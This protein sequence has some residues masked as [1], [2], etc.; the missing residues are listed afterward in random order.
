MEAIVKISWSK[1]SSGMWAAKL[2]TTSFND[3]DHKKLNIGKTLEF[4]VSDERRCIGY[5]SDIGER[6]PCPRFEKLNSGYQCSSCRRKDVYTGYIEGRKK[7]RVDS[8]FSVY[9][10]RCG[11][12]I[13]VGV[14]RS[15]KIKKRWIEQG[16]DKAVEIYSGL[17]SEQAL[18]KEK[19]L[20]ENG[21]KQKIRKEKKLQKPKKSI[22]NVLENI[23]FETKIGD[24]VSLYGKTIYPK[25]ICKN[26]YRKGRF[27]GRIDSVK[28]QIFSTGDLCMIA[29]PGKTIKNPIQKGLEEYN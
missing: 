28:G 16:A 27:K 15:K 7:A 8:D 2:L 24:I 10:A 5:I 1:D 4:E 20:S 6:T 29:S 19:E 21:I 9:I 12:E 26:M 22:E 18:Q 17:S 25:M 23:G 14:T 13:K 3:F 11:S